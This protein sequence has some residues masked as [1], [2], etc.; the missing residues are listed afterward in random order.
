MKPLVFSQADHDQIGR[1]TRDRVGLG[2][3]ERY[4]GSAAAEFQRY[5][6]PTNFHRY[7]DVFSERFGHDI[8][9]GSVLRACHAPE[10]RLSIVDIG[11]GSPLGALMVELLSFVRP[12]AVLLLGMCGGL[13]QGYKVGEL[14]NPVAAIRDEGT[15]DFF[16]P[17][18]CPALASFP[19]QRRV[20]HVLEERGLTYHTG[21]IHTT[22]VRFWE[23]DQPFRERLRL[24]RAQAID[25]EC[26]T[27]FT[28]AYARQVALGALML[29]SDLPLRQSGIKT[30]S[31]ARRVFEKYTA[32]HI[33][34]GIAVVEELQHLKVN[35]FGQRP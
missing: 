1:L 9:H 34:A 10:V 2:T 17:P 15:S 32:Q 26:A 23:F 18:Q 8:R 16:M 25:M 4:T 30:K 29:I 31:S 13:R 21:V 5:V 7:L 12:H 22:N 19:V 35:V 6:L 20:A 24:E 14:F 27:L 33:A 3:L 11:V 28:V